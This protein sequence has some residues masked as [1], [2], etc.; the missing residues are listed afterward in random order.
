MQPEEAK[1]RRIYEWRAQVFTT[2]ADILAYSA[3][4]IA[5]RMRVFGS[6]LP[7]FS[8]PAKAHV[9]DLG[10]GIGLY[11][12]QLAA[13]GYRAVGADF[14]VPSLQRAVAGDGVG[15]GHYVGGEAYALPF[16]DESFDLVLSLGVFALVSE[17]LRMLREVARVLR[18][19]AILVMESLNGRSVV[20]HAWRLRAAV[21]RKPHYLRSYDRTTVNGWLAEAGMT[22]QGARGIYVTPSRLRRLPT[23][24]GRPRLQGALDRYSRVGDLAAHALLFVARKQEERR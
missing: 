22:P 17:P 18:P 2:D 24:L 10:C 21:T 11:V 7:R 8:L 9:L 16:R 12:R 20:A 4:G 1:W 5:T 13:A 6:L 3:H 14:S 19:G 23:V 15:G